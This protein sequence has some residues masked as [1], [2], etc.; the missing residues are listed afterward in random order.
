[1]FVQ[2]VLKRGPSPAIPRR[3]Q[4]YPASLFRHHSTGS[5]SSR[6]QHTEMVLRT[7]GPSTSTSPQIRA[8][9]QSPEPSPVPRTYAKTPL[10][11]TPT[12][13]NYPTLPILHQ[14]PH[15]IE[16][17]SLTTVMR[18]GGYP[19]HPSF[20]D[21]HPPR[22]SLKSI[23]KTLRDANPSNIGPT[24]F[25]PYLRTNLHIL[26]KKYPEGTKVRVL[27]STLGYLKIPQGY[28]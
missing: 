24:P 23:L 12:M 16:Q 11:L 15:P 5:Q 1:M 21:P 26:E 25:A 6:K 8:S 7:Q 13:P 3:G 14:H 17:R 18:P 28:K 19:I 4:I 2:S 27:S 10:K 9:Q 22:P 20:P